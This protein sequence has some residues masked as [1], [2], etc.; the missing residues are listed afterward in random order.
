MLINFKNLN[1]SD[2]DKFV[3]KENCVRSTGNLICNVDGLILFEDKFE[4][5][6]GYCVV[7]STCADIPPIKIYFFEREK[8]ENFYNNLVCKMSDNCSYC[9]IDVLKFGSI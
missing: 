7:G 1:F 9:E 3:S 6:T 2:I 8:A 5:F 4:N